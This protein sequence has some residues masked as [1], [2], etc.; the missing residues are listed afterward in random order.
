MQVA[1]NTPA[2]TAEPIAMPRRMGTAVLPAEMT[3][4]GAISPPHNRKTASGDGDS[5]NPDLPL[6]SSLPLLYSFI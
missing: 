6:Q 3:A 1:N 2:A 5:S 4:Q